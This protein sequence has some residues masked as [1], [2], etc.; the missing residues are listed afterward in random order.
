MYYLIVRIKPRKKILATMCSKKKGNKKLK[1]GVTSWFD[2]YQY[3]SVLN[4][5]SSHL[6]LVLIITFIMHHCIKY[7]AR[8]GV[9]YTL[10]FM[11]LF[12]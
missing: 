5:T 3:R 11:Q 6:F 9:M 10:K 2:M 12:P 7:C 8:N 1:L 4:V